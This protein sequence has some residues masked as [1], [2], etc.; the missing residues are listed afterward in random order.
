MKRRLI[1]PEGFARFLQTGGH[2][3]RTQRQHDVEETMKRYSM[4]FL[5]DLSKSA[6]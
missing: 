3:S 1:L 5:R 6:W 4:F 2:A